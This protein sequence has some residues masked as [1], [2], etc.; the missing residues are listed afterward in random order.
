MQRCDGTSAEQAFEN[1]LLR[2]RI[3]SHQDVEVYFHT[4]TLEDRARVKLDKNTASNHVKACI[5]KMKRPGKSNK[6]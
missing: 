3:A 2:E 5:N 1:M 4:Y 6:G